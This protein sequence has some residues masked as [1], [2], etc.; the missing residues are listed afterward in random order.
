MTVI[1]QGILFI[2]FALGA[3]IGAKVEAHHS[4]ATFDMTK[5]HT[6]NGTIKEVKWQN[7][8]VWIYMVIDANGQQEEWEIEGGSVVGLKREGWSKD[9]YK[10]GDKVSIT[11]HPRR[12]G[13]HG[14]SYLVGTTAGGKTLGHPNE[15]Q[16]TGTAAPAP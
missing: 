15:Q 6:L 11:I 3:V 9:S 8:H 5:Q 4:F 2:A 10:V 12:D 13:T 7:P 1:R 16:V 14:G